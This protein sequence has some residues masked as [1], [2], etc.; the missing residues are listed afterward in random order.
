MIALDP[1]MVEA[2]GYAHW[3]QVTVTIEG[4]A[5]DGTILEVEEGTLEVS[6]EPPVS[7]Q[8]SM[9]IAAPELATDAEVQAIAEGMVVGGV[10]LGIDWAVRLLDGR[11]FMI[12]VGLLRV[13]SAEW[14]PRTGRIKATVLDLGQAI[15]DDRFLL[16]RTSQGSTKVAVIGALLAESVPGW[17]LEVEPGVVDSTLYVTTWDEDRAAAVTDIARSLG[18]WWRWKHDGGWL[19]KRVPDGS[20]PPAWTLTYADAAIEGGGTAGREKTYNAVVA[21]GQLPSDA[22]ENDPPPYAIAYDSDP[23]SPTWWDGPFGHKPRFYASP[24]MTTAAQCL[25]A[26]QSILS[27]AKGLTRAFKLKTYAH[28]G[29]EPGDVISVTQPDASAPDLLMVDGLTLSFGDGAMTVQVRRVG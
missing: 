7:R 22:P 11:E 4:G 3:R 2:L 24:V 16:P 23:A 21:T 1:G 10:M 5:H 26:A 15:M 19:L 17:T 9:T 18:S 6:K 28:P 25:T 20:S 29:L 8:G 12:R 14:A 13:E 27:E